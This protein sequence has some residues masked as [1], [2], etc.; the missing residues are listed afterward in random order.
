MFRAI[1]VATIL[2]NTF[3]SFLLKDDIFITGLPMA[4]Q[5][6]NGLISVFFFYWVAS[7]ANPV[8]VCV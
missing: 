2:R 7:M 5:S 3:I 8:G 6:E 1:I 4:I